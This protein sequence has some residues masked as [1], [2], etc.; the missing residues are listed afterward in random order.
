MQWMQRME[1]LRSIRL[2]NMAWSLVAR[3]SMQIDA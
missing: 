2:G 3:M 1:R